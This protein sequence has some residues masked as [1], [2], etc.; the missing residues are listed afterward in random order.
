MLDSCNKRQTEDIVEQTEEWDG[1]AKAKLRGFSWRNASAVVI[2]LKVYSS[3]AA[4]RR[5]A[6]W[7]LAC[8][9]LCIFPFLCSALA[10][11]PFAAT[12]PVYD[13]N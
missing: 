10:L 3:P 8:R 12:L 11:Y 7:I 4:D 5:K 9:V 6:S 13:L 2:R 1:G